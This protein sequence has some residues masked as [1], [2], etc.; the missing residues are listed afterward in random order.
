MTT[1]L[2]TFDLDPFAEEFILEPY[3]HYRA[4]RDAGPV[5]RLEKY[6]VLAVARFDGVRTTMKDHT[7]FRSSYGPG[8]NDPYNEKMQGTVVASEPPEH[9]EIRATMVKRLRLAKLKEMQPLADDLA[10]KL[11]TQFLERGTF[12]AASDMARP[13]VSAFAGTVLGISPEIAEMAIDGSYAGFNSTGPINERT[14]AAVPVIEQLFGMMAHLTKDDFTAGSIGWDLL[15]AHER[16]EIPYADSLSL[17]FNF[18][19]PAFDTTINAVGVTLWLLANHPEQWAALR[20]DP[21]L[22]A[23]T[24]NESLR[25]DSPLQVWSRFCPEGAVLDGAEIPPD[26]RVVV[27]PGSA[28]RDER[29]YADPDTFDIRRNPVDH[30]GFGQGIHMCVGAPLARMEL[31]SVLTAFVQL[32]RTIEPAGEPTR[33]FNNTTRGYSA[34]PV[35]IS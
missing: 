19:G 17:I 3:E 7:V 24:I 1:A 15:D 2:P 22:I 30:L 11:T 20:E 6:D 21:A 13:F 8:L 12:D 10:H 5:V 23:A 35:R 14:L 9:T 31:T 4:M 29:H 18:L 25:F 27:L 34:A 16:G 32:V 26:T 33:R 28:N